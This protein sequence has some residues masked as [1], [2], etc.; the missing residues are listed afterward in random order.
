[1]HVKRWWYSHHL[2]VQ[3]HSVQNGMWKLSNVNARGFWVAL[4]IRWLRRPSSQANL[5]SRSITVVVRALT[6]V[7]RSLGV[8]QVLGIFLL[9]ASCSL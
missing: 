1:M 2:D 3:A 8:A 6:V 9:R 7:D 5:R 4:C